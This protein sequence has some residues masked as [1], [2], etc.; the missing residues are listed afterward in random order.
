MA[1]L[2][3]N[4]ELSILDSDSK[5]L[6]AVFNSDNLMGQT[7]YI[8]S[9]NKAVI[10]QEL[11][12]ITEMLDKLHSSLIHLARSLKQRVK[13]EVSRKGLF[14]SL[15]SGYKLEGSIQSCY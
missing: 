5:L 1:K 2:Q 7:V 13:F 6:W 8:N 3:Q 12:E 4:E 15:K 9:E 11:S 10:F 14:L